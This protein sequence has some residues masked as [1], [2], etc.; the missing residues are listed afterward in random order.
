MDTNEQPEP[1]A[2]T[3]LQPVQVTST[4]RYFWEKMTGW[5]L[6]SSVIGL[7]RSAFWIFMAI[8]VIAVGFILSRNNLIGGS[9]QALLYFL[10]GG[11]ACLAIAACSVMMHV[12]QIQYFNGIKS[13]LRDYDQHKFERAW[14]YL[15]IHFKIQGILFIVYLL[16]ILT[17]VYL[18]PARAYF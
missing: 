6:F 5:V 7:L 16:I 13:S 14:N 3:A 1:I 15:R 8:Y 17:I 11:F 12:R 9:D 2:Y 18:I 4:M 10:A